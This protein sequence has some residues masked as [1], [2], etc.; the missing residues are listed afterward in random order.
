MAFTPEWIAF[1][2]AAARPRPGVG[3]NVEVPLHRE[4]KLALL[5]PDAAPGFAEV[6]QLHRM[7]EP[8]ARSGNDAAVPHG[9]AGSLRHE[10]PLAGITGPELDRLRIVRLKHPHGLRRREQPGAVEE[11]AAKCGMLQP[12]D[13]HRLGAAILHGL[14]PL[15]QGAAGPHR[16]LTPVNQWRAHRRSAQGHLQFT[17]GVPDAFHG[18]RHG[19]Q[20]TMCAQ[21]GAEII[22][23]KKTVGQRNIPAAVHDIEEITAR[24]DRLVQHPAPRRLAVGIAPD[25][26]DGRALV[27]IRCDR[28]AQVRPQLQAEERVFDHEQAPPGRVTPAGNWFAELAGVPGLRAPGR[29]LALAPF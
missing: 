13:R 14:A 7:I 25:D 24:C 17:A 4:A 8:A 5:V 21:R 20:F 19:A 29:R 22:A 16:Q 9:P 6:R 12:G 27:D 10:R 1:H 28:A 11:R 26:V 15:Q 23:G 18:P 2:A 3:I